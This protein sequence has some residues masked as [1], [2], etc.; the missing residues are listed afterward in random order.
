MLSPRRLAS[1]LALGAIWSLTSCAPSTRQPRAVVALDEAFAAARPELAAR[2]ENPSLF[3]DGP[4]GRF[5]PPLVLRVAMSDGAGKALD[6]AIATAKKGGRPTILAT[7]P[8]IAKAIIEGGTWS[9]DPP[10]LVPESTENAA[11]GLW[12]ALTDPVPAYSEA[13]RAAGAYI[14]ALAR[15][16]GTPSCGILYSEAPSRPRAALEAF[17]A[18][19]AEAS[20]S[21]PLELREIAEQGSSGQAAEA[22][23]SQSVPAPLPLSPSSAAE[24]GV[25]ELLGSDI[26][27]LFVVLGAAS[28][29]AIRAAESPGMA[30]G[31]VFASPEWPS[32]LAFRVL[33]DD[34][35]LAR[36]LGR[37]RLR[38]SPAARG[39]GSEAVPARLSAGP[40]AGNLHAGKR[41]FASFLAEASIRPKSAGE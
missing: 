39:G 14:A 28:A 18:A 26:R 32:S 8:L 9:G 40:A 3:G 21:R 13:G 24:A 12:T 34:E 1:L 19:Y 27:V 31:A 7:S 4:L 25:K 37:L 30:I 16:G 33:P 2:L 41:D 35:A 17:T 6:T 38:I 15:E 36:A 23:K 10:L 20:G 11:P 5:P 29:A 22:A